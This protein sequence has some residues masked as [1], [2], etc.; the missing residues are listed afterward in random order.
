MITHLK[1]QERRREQHTWL[2]LSPQLRADPLAGGFEELE[3]FNED[4]LPPAASIARHPHH[5]AEILTYVREGVL[6]YEDSTGSS[7]VI[8]AGEFQR[9][10]AGRGIRHV[11]TNPS[12]SEWTHV[13]QLW[14]RPAE[15]ALGP[16]HEQKRFCVAQRRG[17]LCLIA[18]PDARRGSLRVRQD[19][20]MYAAMLGAGQHVVHELLPGRHAWLHVVQ[21]EAALDDVAL[22][23]G[24]CASITA[25]RAVSLRALEETEI[26][27]F[28]LGERRPRSLAAL[29]AP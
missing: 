12:R 29:A 6:A 5:D 21:G 15:S 22:V 10:S 27:L 18:S 25:E 20:S 9:M 2:T 19:V 11:E 28:D 1:A 16:S 14:L 3:I 23:S 26:L 8:H 24:D 4:R 17:G 7:G 13:F